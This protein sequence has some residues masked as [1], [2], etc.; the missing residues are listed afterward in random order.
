M[1][2]DVEAF[3]EANSHCIKYEQKQDN[4]SAKSDRDRRVQ[5]CVER[6]IDS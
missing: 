4:N 6:K 5:L 3:H 1:R 2:N